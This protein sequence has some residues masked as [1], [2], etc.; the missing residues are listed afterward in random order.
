MKLDFLAPAA[1]AVFLSVAPAFATTA[2]PPGG[3]VDLFDYEDLEV[4]PG[5]ATY[6]ESLLDTVVVS[7]TETR[8]GLVGGMVVDDLYNV[9]LE[10][11][12][13]VWRGSTGLLTFGY[14]YAV[15]EDCCVGINGSTDFSIDGF[16]GFDVEFGYLARFGS[17][18]RPDVERS[19]DGDTLSIG[20]FDPRDPNPN[21]E[22]FLFVTDATD[23]GL[24]G[25]GT[26]DV[27]ID[28]FGVTSRGVSGLPTPAVVP[29]PAA[30]PLVAF[31]LG[32]LGVARRRRR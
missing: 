1:A 10:L 15:T 28:T 20:Y 4:A 17:P 21:I 30:L 9:T 12:A 7:V 5:D 24:A 13:R 16:A 22:T 14:D 29:L 27:L 31:S 23:Y 3:M 18:Y 8:G 26:L 32:A 2:L 11:T 19:P 6:F 25:T